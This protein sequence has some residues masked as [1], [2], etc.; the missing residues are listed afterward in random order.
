M[1]PF[2]F[3][4][5]LKPDLSQVKIFGSKCYK[6]QFKEK[7]VD[8]LANMS[9]QCLYVGH[10]DERV[11]TFLFYH[12]EEGKVTEGGISKFD[13]YGNLLSTFDSTYIHNFEVKSKRP[14]PYLDVEQYDLKIKS[15]FDADVYDDA[16]D[17]ETYI[18]LRIMT[19]DT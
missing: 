9:E 10:S 2:E 7:R 15:I 3:V 17:N 4:T 11:N 5:G 6:F 19:L 18:V 8:K 12:R 13:E 14:E 1:S 16:D